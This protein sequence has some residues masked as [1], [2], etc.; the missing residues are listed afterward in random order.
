M[1][2]ST[3]ENVVLWNNMCS[4]NDIRSFEILFHKLNT[5]LIKFC[6]FYINNKEAAEEIVSDV[7]VRCWENRLTLAHINDPSTYLFVAVKNGSLNYLKKYSQVHLVQIEDSHEL[8][9]V[10]SYD[11]VKALE[12]KE[13]H[14]ILDRAIDCLPMQSK[15][16]FRLI[17]E[18][19]MRYKQVAEILNISTRTVQ[20]QL[21]RAIKKLTTTLVAHHIPSQHKAANAGN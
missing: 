6:V 19:G 2:S 1:E 16:I 12:R 8:V 7:F 9:F 17:K 10:N 3:T 13:L 5:K 18:D 14:F 21:F 15:L 4:R 11:P 20:T